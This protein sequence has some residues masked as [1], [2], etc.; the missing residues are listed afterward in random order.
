MKVEKRDGS[1]VVLKVEMS[2]VSWDEKRVVLK[3]VKL[4]EK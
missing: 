4:D 3:V 2:V 1:M